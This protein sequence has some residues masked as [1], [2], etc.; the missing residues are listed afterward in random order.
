LSKP[1]KKLPKT[2]SGRK[3]PTS[4]KLLVKQKPVIK[5][6][7]KKVEEKRDVPEDTA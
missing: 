7:V 3:A 2:P 5:K 6:E 1:A 4:S